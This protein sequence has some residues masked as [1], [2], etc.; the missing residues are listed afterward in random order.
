MEK[1][2]KKILFIALSVLLAVVVLSL[3]GYGLW[4]YFHHEK[5]PK[6]KMIIVGSDFTWYS[7]GTAKLNPDTA[8]TAFTVVK[9]TSTAD[10]CGLLAKVNASTI[11]IPKTYLDG[12]TIGYAGITSATI[13][14]DSTTI[15]FVLS[16]GSDPGY[17]ALTKVDMGSSMYDVSVNISKADAKNTIN[18][19][20]YT[21]NEYLLTRVGG[22]SNIKD[23]TKPNS[24]ITI[25]GNYMCF[26]SKPE[27][28]TLVTTDEFI[29]YTYLKTFAIFNVENIIRIISGVGV[30]LVP[31]SIIDTS[32]DK[33]NVYGNF[34][35]GRS[36]VKSFS[37]F[38]FLT[39]TTDFNVI[40]YDN[41]K[42]SKK[43]F[44]VSIFS[45]GHDKL[46]NEDKNNKVEYAPGVMKF[47]DIK[48][49]SANITDSDSWII[50][51]IN[52]SNKDYY[53]G[54]NLNV[55]NTS[56]D[57]AIGTFTNTNTDDT[58]YL[59][60]FGIP[61][62][63]IYNKNDTVPTGAS[64]TKYGF[65][66]INTLSTGST[67]YGGFMLTWSTTSGDAAVA[68]GYSKCLHTGSKTVMTLS[69]GTFVSLYKVLVNT[70]NGTANTDKVKKDGSLF[71]DFFQQVKS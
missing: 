39:A 28:T 2:T 9:V 3:V 55:K 35:I 5:A 51:P 49:Q 60:T 13:S 68:G 48:S 20:S 70:G 47:M 65:C 44:T 63:W 16:S 41:L 71:T 32:Q 26:L 61:V 18:K 15:D 33:P 69:G 31:E 4:R 12:T 40:Y 24:T 46:T 42:D 53:V 50:C 59:T 19:T 43:A 21:C 30:P 1:K 6:D 37:G 64:D 56:G 25:V 14:S 52:V 29:S 22:C 27:V 54:Y 11:S 7:V 62:G 38:S 45:A 34:K 23:V 10:N 66:Q 17:I 58:I 67:I 57:C 36:K 8:P